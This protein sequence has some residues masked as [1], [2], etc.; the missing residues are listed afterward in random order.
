M[1]EGNSKEASI[2]DEAAAFVKR[3][4]EA[5]GVVV[6]GLRF[7]W[8]DASS[9]EKR[10]AIVQSVQVDSETMPRVLCS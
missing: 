2:H 1:N 5:H 8:A 3:I 10:A 9:P 4:F 6:H 7:D